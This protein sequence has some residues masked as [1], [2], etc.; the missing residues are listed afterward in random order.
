[1]MS[2]KLKKS[3]K[4]NKKSIDRT[5]K[6]F[7]SQP[8]TSLLIKE[9]L[10]FHQSGNLDRAREVY[11]SILKI[12]PDHFDALQLLGVLASQTNQWANAVEFFQKAISLQ[13][14]S[15]IVF[16][17]QGIAFQ[18]LNLL[19]QALVS[20]CNAIQLE[21]NY[22]QAIY[23]KAVVLKGLDRLDDALLCYDKVIELKPDYAEAY[24]NRGNILEHKTR[25]ADALDDF[26]K[27]TELKAEHPEGYINRGRVLW[28]L[29]SLEQSL[30]NYD[31]AIELEPGFAQAYFGKGV[32]QGE[33]NKLVDAVKSYDKATYLKHDFSIAFNNLGS[34]FKKL[35]NLNQALSNYDR[36]IY[37]GVHYA[38][39]YSNRG[40]VLQKLQRFDEAISDFIKAISLKPDFAEF[41]YNYGNLLA[42]S[43]RI[44]EA[45]NEY[46]KAIELRID[47]ADCYT[48][49]SILLQK[50][51][52]LHEA[53]AS[54]EMAIE[55]EPTLAEAYFN[56]G[57]ISAELKLVDQAL[58][59]YGHSV[60]IKPNYFDAH[61]NRG[62]ILNNLDRLD[63]S[64]SCYERAI[65]IKPDFAQAHWNYALAL[66]LCGDFGRGFKEYE[67]RWQTKSIRANAG[68]RAFSQ[69]LWNG[70][71]SLEHKTILLYCE[72]G[73]GDTLQFCRYASLVAQLG[74][75]VLLEVQEPLVELLEKIEGV[76]RV[77]PKG[78]VLPDFDYQCPLM[79]LPF[80]FNTCINTVPSKGPYLSVD[81]TRLKRWESK[82]GE[83]T[84]PRI[85]I[86]WSSVSSFKDD[87]KRSV[88]FKE[89][90]SCF[91][92][93]SF[94][95]ICLQ[96]E[97][98]EQ[99]KAEFESSGLKFYGDELIDFSET[100][101][102]IECLDLVVGTCT[103]V[104]HLSAALGKPTWIMLQ[105]VPDWRWMRNICHSPWYPTVRLYRQQSLADWSE[106]F[107][108]VRADL[109]NYLSNWMKA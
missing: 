96:K 51:N 80:A 37:H 91:P 94:D 43:G 103:S 102:L 8:K 29:K 67:W 86:V 18:E 82:L 39:A 31:K 53:L 104:P 26:S 50:L 70:K 85:G 72:Q 77:L 32:V 28:K 3:S 41:F 15:A 7:L 44:E 5:S 38:Q 60:W 95:I 58:N 52:R 66:L 35:G 12:D 79:S 68:Q 106:V 30:V 64:L 97:V 59:S 71:E 75:R 23:N 40:L 10:S 74:A 100:A 93:G 9:G 88:T 101:A 4:F 11:L 47:Y 14:T 78:S 57:V 45:L 16:F 22:V 20:Y 6:N 98:K 42:E 1:M 69:P 109:V 33:L 63:E 61:Y 62:V 27:V 25:Y 87:D 2:S 34:V 89:I 92:V 84:R 54:C 108:E 46:G 107:N 81:K 73:L 24:S 13:S 65:E 56:R 17:N 36:S 99:D 105:K 55:F 19:D 21:S 49:R 76:F 83:K 90:I 48:H